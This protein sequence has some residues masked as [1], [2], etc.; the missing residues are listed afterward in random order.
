MVGGSVIGLNR[1]VSIGRPRAEWN[2]YEPL[3]WLIPLGVWCVVTI[4][5]CNTKAHLP[6]PMENGFVEPFLCGLISGIVPLARA[7]VG[8]QS[9]ETNRTVTRWSIF[10]ASAAAVGVCFVIPPLRLF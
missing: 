3:A 1:I 6:F 2:G 10:I 8:Q 5:F 7:V 9:D 4:L